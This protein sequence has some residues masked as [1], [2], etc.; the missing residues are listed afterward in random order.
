MRV[1]AAAAVRWQWTRTHRERAH[2]TIYWVTLKCCDL[3]KPS[4]YRQVGLGPSGGGKEAC[5]EKNV[6]AVAW[7]EEI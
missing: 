7:L 5:T 1:E 3:L 4:H 6:A 2:C